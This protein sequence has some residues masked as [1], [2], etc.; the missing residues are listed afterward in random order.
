MKLTGILACGTYFSPWTPYGLASFYFCDEIIVV[1]GGYDIENFDMKEYN[2]PLKQVSR[3][4]E[5]LDV[6]GKI[7]EVTGFTIDDL[8]HKATIARQHDKLPKEWYDLRGLNITL[9]NEIAVERGAD[10]ILKWDSDQTGYS[11]AVKVRDYNTGLVLKQF[12]F[13]GDVHHLAV[14]P[15]TSPFNDSIFS[16]IAKEGQWYY[17]GMAP[18]INASREFFEDG[19]CAHLRHANPLHLSEEQK[20]AHFYGRMWFRYFTNNGLLGDELHEA[21]KANAENLLQQ[22]GKPSDVPPPEVC[23]TNPLTYIEEMIECWNQ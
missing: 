8:K 18:V 10:M 17:G 1:N 13:V 15:P 12:E 7:V 21:A 5:E 6:Q 22:E 9:A 11:N 16:Y 2:I 19:W 20:F 3:D 4:I 23:L 14:P